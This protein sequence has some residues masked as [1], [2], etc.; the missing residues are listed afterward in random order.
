[1]KLFLTIL[2]WIYGAVIFL[3]HR[4]YDWGIIKSYE[5]DIPVVC[6]GNITV[7]GTGKTPMAVFVIR[8]PIATYTIALLSRGYGRIC[9]VAVFCFRKERVVPVI[10]FS[11][12]SACI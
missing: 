9:Q 1:M 7:G 8:A 2:S 5:F 10:A 3:R 4:L 12:V 11:T 6:I